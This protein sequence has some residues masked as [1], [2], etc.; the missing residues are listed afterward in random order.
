MTRIVIDFLRPKAEG[1][2]KEEGHLEW[3]Q[4]RRLIE[5]GSVIVASGFPVALWGGVAEV[6]VAPTGPSWC[7]GVTERVKSGAGPAVVRYVAVPDVEEIAYTDLIEVDPT[8]L[9]PSAEPE[10]A[11][12]AYAEGMVISGQQAADAAATAVQVAAALPGQAAAAVSAEVVARVDPKVSIATDAASTAATK[13]GE[14]VVSAQTAADN[15]NGF[16]IGIVTGLAAGATPTASITGT[17]PNRKL[18]LGIAQG[19]KGDPGGFTTG[20][21]LG[22]VSLDT[23][24]TPGLYRQGTSAF[25]TTAN[26]YPIAGSNGTGVLEV[27]Q[28][29]T[30]PANGILQRYTPVWGNASGK[31]MFERTLFSS[32]WTGWQAFTSTRT[33]QTAGRAIYQWDELNNREQLIYGDT[34]IRRATPTLVNNAFFDVSDSV[35][36]MFISRT[37]KEVE[38]SGQLLATASFSTVSAVAIPTGFRPKSLVESTA[39][40][41][42]GSTALVRANAP[43]VSN[44]LSVITVP[45]SPLGGV[46][47]GDIINITAR[48]LTDDPWPTT[49]PGTASGSIPNL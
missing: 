26:K 48:W 49:L 10:A 28:Q 7:W 13:A 33:D 21:V 37:G 34:G 45:G 46:V 5:G 41:I 19:G 47:A 3:Q 42:R 17:A 24:T 15:A 36:F 12:W 14:A 11:W 27:I 8:T 31:I 30:I 22:D 2:V 25:C 40:Q 4:T 16:D 20:T 29:G 39:L 43:A 23:I 38:V 44:A 32:S 6:N 35:R 1:R 18:N 9:L